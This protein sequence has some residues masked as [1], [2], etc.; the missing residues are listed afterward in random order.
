MFKS[1]R[2]YAHRGAGFFPRAGAVSATALIGTVVWYLTLFQND[3]LWHL[4]VAG[5]QQ[6][7]G[8]SDVMRLATLGAILLAGTFTVA[9]TLCVGRFLRVGLALF[10]LIAVICNYFMS[11][12]GVL[13]DAQMLINAVRTNAR[14]A[15]ELVTAS[16]LMRV[17]LFGGL[18]AAII[19]FVPIR[20]GS[21]ACEI[22]R[23]SGVALLLW[24]V[25]A[26]VLLANY[27]EAAL[28]ARAHSEVRKYPNPVYPLISAYKVAR[29]SLIAPASAAE[30]QRIANTVEPRAGAGR[31]RIV[32]M[33]VGETAR[34]D[35]FS[36]FGYSRATNPRLAE[37]PALLRF[38]DVRSCGTSTAVSVPCMF[39]RLDHDEFDRDAAEARENLL[40]VLVHAGVSVL[41]RENNTGCQGV[42]VRVE[43]ETL[44]SAQDAE[45]CADGECRDEILLAGLR[46]R[47]KSNAGDQLIVLHQLGSHGP[48]YYKRYP[49]GFA[50]FMPECALDD[51]Y[52]CSRDALVNSYDNTVLYTDHVLSELI[53]ILSV[54]GQDADT[55]M[56]YVSDHGESLGEN[57]MYLHGFPYALAPAAQTHVPMLAWVS[58]GFAES[59]GLSEKC[60]E[61]RT[62]DR[63]SHDNVFDILLGLFGVVTDVYRPDAD[64]VGQCRSSR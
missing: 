47:F 5:T 26:A 3:A 24:A 17:L 33:V 12:Y 1:P 2:F 46:D 39:S 4:A 37:I 53:R 7:L 45:H 41:W 9:A 21:L 42:C 32:V 58:P 27:K 25:A 28:W 30:I 55:A 6:P 63:L 34:A 38:A 20:Q 60:L 19:L 54:A 29:G 23:R 16:L 13:I 50:R 14:E 57:G 36:L 62:Q 22:L 35:H 52:R 49:P 64:V 59:L 56:L 40:D 15:G 8:W 44:S 18:P 11:R 48:S 10:V 43:T 31:R 61:A 51:A